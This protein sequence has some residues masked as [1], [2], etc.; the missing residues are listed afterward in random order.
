M[1]T[2][3]PLDAYL[4]Q[5]LQG[6]QFEAAVIGASAGGVAALMKILPGLPPGVPVPVVVVVHMLRGRSSQLA[7][8]FASRLAVPVREAADKDDV[9][10]GAV[11]FAPPDY[12]L[13]VENDGTFSLSNEPLHIFSRPAIDFAMQSAADA[14][15]PA[16]VGILLTGASHDGAAGLAAIGAAGGLTVVQDPHEA[17]SPLM[18]EAAIRLWQPDLILPLRD[19][20]TLLAR[21]RAED[22]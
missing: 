19:I 5:V 4:A 6:R 20:R 9:A 22:A 18:P 13:S 1:N 12:H 8:L 21:L 11:Y 15:G 14:F 7:E 17:Q 10:P 2:P 3:S 16:L